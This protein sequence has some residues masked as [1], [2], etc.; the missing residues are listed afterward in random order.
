MSKTV[1]PHRPHDSW[2][3]RDVTC[4]QT[5][6]RWA[7]VSKLRTW[8][9]E[10]SFSLSLSSPPS[11]LLL[12]TCSLGGGEPGAEHV[13]LRGGFASP[14]HAATHP[15]DT[16]AAAAAHTFEG[17]RQ[18]NQEH[19]SVQG[20]GEDPLRQGGEEEPAQPAAQSLSG[21]PR[22]VTEARIFVD[23][24]PAGGSEVSRGILIGGAN[25]WS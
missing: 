13:G 8:P 11:T 3:S 20:A 23:P 24:R 5:W 17:R 9:T 19:V 16:A 22:W 15:A 25:R 2:E 18:Q 7:E 1:E 10:G 12:V 6:R 14:R 4:N 21:G